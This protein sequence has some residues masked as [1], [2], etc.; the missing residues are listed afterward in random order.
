[1]SK[2]QI[3]KDF[4]ELI[5]GRSSEIQIEKYYKAKKKEM[6]ML[7][8]M[9]FLLL[10]ISVFL[11]F[12]STK[13]QENKLKR[14]SYGEGKKEVPL[15]VKINENNWTPFVMVLEEK[16]FTEEEIT[17]LYRS[18]VN[19][20]P[21][22]IKKEN[23]D[24]E[25]VNSDLDL[26]VVLEEYPFRISWES[27][28]PEIVDE[29]GTVYFENVTQE[30]KVNLTVLFQYGEWERQEVIS[31]VVKPKNQE[32]YIFYL[33][34]EL[35]EKEALTRKEEE[36]LLPASYLENSLQWRYP[37]SNST[38]V[39]GVLFLIILPFISYQKDAE[40][41]RKLIQ[42]REELQDAFPEFITRLILYLEAGMSVRGAIFRFLQDGKEK[43]KTGYLYEE[44]AYVCRQIKNGLPEK[45]GYE[46]LAV[47]CNLPSYRKLT[48]LLIQ[49]I[50][51]GSNTILDNLRKEA[52][53][54]VEEKKGRIQKRGEEMGTK[55]L[56]PMIIMLLIV[57]V[58]IMVPA[59]FSFQVS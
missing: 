9:A 51:K 22:I 26:V 25:E 4:K 27:S 19:E 7:F 50:Q 48:N 43:N 41:H 59:L 18:L 14:N 45:E 23:T 28:R 46:L 54:A 2:I 17:K 47:R 11:E 58:F 38:V 10:G 44:L 57:M 8:A 24:L 1:M 16:E 35:K 3:E 52:T 15:E 20:L 21:E 29:D 42:R 30:E 32:D 55:L 53:K 31:V 34:K 56:F 33:T 12:Q 40:I 37:F 13:P 6:I 36:F 5:P 39:L 49:H